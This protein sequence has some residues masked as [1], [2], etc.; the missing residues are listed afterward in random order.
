MVMLLACSN[1]PERRQ[2]TTAS[3]SSS[4][5]AAAPGA[6][7][8]DA[9]APSAEAVRAVEA[10]EALAANPACGHAPIVPS[11]AL[12]REIAQHPQLAERRQKAVTTI[13]GH[14]CP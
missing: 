9:A 12:S 2:G 8:S 11:A 1:A 14:P 4:V 6:A 5:V 3:A 7:S 13:A 10:L